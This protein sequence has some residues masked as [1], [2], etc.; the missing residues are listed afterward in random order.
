MRASSMATGSGRGRAAARPVAGVRFSK[1]A[2]RPVSARGVAALQVRAPG[3]GGL[4][5]EGSG[6]A[7]LPG[8]RPHCPG[9]ANGRPPRPR[10]TTDRAPR[11]HQG[12][13]AAGRSLC[14]GERAVSQVGSISR[15]SPR[16]RPGVAEAADRR[17]GQDAGVREAR[18]AA[19]GAGRRAAR[20]FAARRAAPRRGPRRVRGPHRVRCV[21]GRLSAAAAPPTPSGRTPAA[22][23]QRTPAARRP[24]PQS[25]PSPL[26][27]TTRPPP[28]RSRVCPRRALRPGTRRPTRPRVPCRLRL[29]RRSLT[30]RA[31][32]AAPL[33]AR[34]PAGQARPIFPFTAIVG[35]EEMKLALILNVIDPK[36]RGRARARLAAASGGPPRPRG[37]AGAARPALA[38]GAAPAARVCAVARRPRRPRLTAAPPPRTQIGGV[39]IMGDRGT[40][41]ST[42]IRALADLLPEIRVVD[43]DPFNSGARR[44]AD[45]VCAGAAWALCV[46]LCVGGSKAAATASAVPLPPVPSASQAS[47]SRRGRPGPFAARCGVLTPCALLSPLTQTPRTPS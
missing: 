17:G 24:A 45:V 42:T 29:V 46:W 10:I 35:Q 33:R 15:A 23:T 31:P 16:A 9:P 21:R 20:R 27:P 39:M 34:R 13:K 5:T 7:P 4:H 18:R 12:G 2:I 28:S 30:P 11:T 22:D 36:V 3:D 25:S 6:A 43:K 38:L 44:C 1:A 41:K 8:G 26:W 32:P 14:K 40:G 37:G 19:A 47:R